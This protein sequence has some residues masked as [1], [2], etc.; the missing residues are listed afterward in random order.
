M[1]DLETPYVYTVTMM[2][3]TRLI[4]FTVSEF[5]RERLLKAVTDQ[6]PGLLAIR[7]IHGGEI[8]LALH[9]VTWYGESKIKHTNLLSPGAVLEE[10]ARKPIDLNST[11]FTEETIP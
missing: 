10:M 1:I 7:D 8:R 11:L 4:S 5:D 2:V 9:A 3:D 6:P